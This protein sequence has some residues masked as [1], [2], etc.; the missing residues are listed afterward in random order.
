VDPDTLRR[1]ADR[2][3]I[4]VFTTPG[5]HRRFL[6]SAID[7]LVA[8]TAALERPPLSAIAEHPDHIAAEFR[9]RVRTDL[10]AEDWRSRLDEATLRWFRERG[11][12]MSDLLLG[13]LDSTRR[14]ARERLLA[15]AETLGHE[16]GAAAKRAGLSLGEAAQAFLFFRARFMG[17]IAHVARRRAVAPPAAAT[18]FDEADA[19]LDRVIIALTRGHQA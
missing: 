5:G 12:R 19:A 4:R 17:E 6:R 16:Y 18:L 2:G 3:Q 14:A 7:A 9:R 11:V 15:E 13:S 8:G 10:T 1:W